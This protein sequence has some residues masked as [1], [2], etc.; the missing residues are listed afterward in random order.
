MGVDI[1]VINGSSMV[2][3]Y[4]VSSIQNTLQPYLGD[5]LT[6]AFP[7]LLQALAFIPLYFI[8]IQSTFGEDNS[9]ETQLESGTTISSGFITNETDG[10]L[11]RVYRRLSCYIHQDITPTLSQTGFLAGTSA[12]ILAASLSTLLYRLIVFKGLAEFPIRVR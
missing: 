8:P 7:A 6:F 5:R 9:P 12:L 10:P 11:R 2:A 1:C 3:V 4:A